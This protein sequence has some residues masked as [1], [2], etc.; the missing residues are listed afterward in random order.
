M[1]N[2][3]VVR[4]S[5]G[6]FDPGPLNA[7][8]DVPGVRVGHATVIED[9]PLVVRSGVTVVHPLEVGYWQQNV[10]AGFHR[11]NG[12]G[13]VSGIQWLEESGVLTSPICLT[14][15]Y[16]LGM[17]RDTLF[18]HFIETGDRGRSQI[19]VVA[20]TNDFVLSDAPRQPLGPKHVLHAMDTASNG[21]VAEGNVGGGTGNVA[22]LFK[23]GIGTASK[24]ADTPSG[25]FTVG[26]LVQSNHGQRDDLCIDG[27][28]V[29]RELGAARVPYPH[30]GSD[31]PYV[32]M[33]EHL[34]RRAAEAQPEGSIII[35]VATDAPLLPVQCRRLAQRAVV[36]LGRI[37]GIGNNGSGDFVI[38]FSTGNR[39]EAKPAEP[40]GNVRMVPNHHFSP[41]FQATIEATESAILN[42]LLGAKTMTGR[43]GNT[44]YALT[45]SAIR[46]VMEAY[47]RKPPFLNG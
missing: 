15:T 22:Y 10:F 8:T 14:S 37:G 9:A 41:L 18:G 2:D 26:V 31:D 16:S 39:F 23:G 34:A 19:A 11:Y 3:A 35:V 7:I 28:P 44:A 36:G 33:P 21:P 4:G 12:F 17:V 20:E 40:V 5:I 13:E 47:G 24:V 30:I 43:N 42:S 46:E 25:S 1:G 32:V 38:C 6:H 45:A 27:V 29:G